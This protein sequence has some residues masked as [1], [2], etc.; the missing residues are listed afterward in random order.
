MKMNSNGRSAK[1]HS[2]NDPTPG[3]LIKPAGE[4]QIFYQHD[5]WAPSLSQLD[6]RWSVQPLAHSIAGEFS[7]PAIVL[8]QQLDT[9]GADWRAAIRESRA[10]LLRVISSDDAMP[11]PIDDLPVFSMVQITAPAALLRGQICAGREHLLLR[12]RQSELEQQLQ[13]AESEINGLNEIGVAL[14]SQR[15]RKSLLDMILRK[16]REITQSDAG[17]LYLVEDN[18]GESRLRFILTH[19]D[20]AL[21]PFAETLLPIDSAS[22]AGYVALTGT[23]LVLDDVYQ[24]PPALPFRFNAKFDEQTGYRCKSMLTVPMKDPQGEIIGVVQLINCKRDPKLRV[25]RRTVDAVVLP[26]PEQSPLLLRS[27]A[28]QAAVAIENN[29]LIESIETLFEGFVQASVTAIEARDPTTFGHSFRVANL[30]LGLAQAV[31]RAESGALREVH[32]NRAEMK[33]IRYASLLHD[34]GKVAVREEVLV[35]AKKLYPGQLEL[36]QQR[37]A[38]ARKAL[39]HAQSERK[40]SY[41]LEKG[42]EAFLAAQ[43]NMQQ[44]LQAQLRELD[45]FLSFVARCNEPSIL[46]QGNFER[47]AQLAGRQF[48]DANGENLQLL[49]VQEAR[50]LSIPQGSLDEAE[51]LQIQSHVTHTQ[52]FLQQIPWTKEIKNVPAIAS[53][54]HEKLD[55]SGYPRGLAAQEIP[56]QSKMMTIADIFDALSAGDRPYKNAVPWERA[57]DILHDEA[58]RGLI[59]RSLLE[60][61]CGAE[62]FRLVKVK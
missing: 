35:K 38:Y 39:Q 20:S 54:H 17:S 12:R 48:T 51:R 49:S 16:S 53:A 34:F 1:S 57:L 37:F 62:I 52:S 41:L 40:L 15:D 13:R 9:L 46:H 60:I 28:S 61:F 25:D 18:G 33:E 23:E 5:T 6:S 26:F 50:L 55:G 19:N 29:R 8:A 56:I 27:L 31:D 32:F 3:G 10:L 58:R 22:I 30:T 11:S 14:S 45:E 42:R 7:T 59:D 43:E 47:L 4:L 2:V 21:M 24:I 44:E 36:I